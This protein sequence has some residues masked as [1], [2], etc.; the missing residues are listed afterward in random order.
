MSKKIV[1]NLRVDE[2]DWLQI[3]TMAAE[4]GMSVNEYVNYLIKD[5]SLRR[6]L[7]TDKKIAKKKARELAPIWKLGEIAKRVK[8]SPLGELS[9]DDKLIYE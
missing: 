9:S 2:N 5:L 8:S 6:E 3:K 1:T 4:M 7:F